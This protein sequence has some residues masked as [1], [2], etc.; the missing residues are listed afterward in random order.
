MVASLIDRLR[1]ARKNFGFPL[2]LRGS[3]SSLNRATML[4]NSV[5]IT[6]TMS[7][8]DGRRPSSPCTAILRRPS[9]DS[10]L[11]KTTVGGSP[12]ATKTALV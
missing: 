5:S 11:V 3:N 4:L 6:R 1:S 12:K 10:N 9:T 7:P 8:M 2:G